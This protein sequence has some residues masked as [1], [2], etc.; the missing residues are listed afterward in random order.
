MGRPH[1]SP[2]PSRAQCRQLAG[3]P[4]SVILAPLSSLPSSPTPAVCELRVSSRPPA[5]PPPTA[6]QE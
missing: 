2:L 3:A 6:R 1:M 4:N 5:P